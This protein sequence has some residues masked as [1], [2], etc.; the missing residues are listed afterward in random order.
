MNKGLQKKT[1]AKSGARFY[2][3]G[4]LG[5]GSEVRL[6]AEA[7]HHAARVLRLNPGDPV[8]LFDGHGGEFEARILRMDRSEVTVKTG[9]HLTVERE[10]PLEILLA[11][12]LSSGDRMDLTL[13]KSVELGVAAIQPVA[14]E[15]SVVKLKDERAAR[16]AEH[17]QNLVIA[18]CEQCGRNRVPPV[19]Q[20]LGL[21]EWLAQ[22][23]KPADDVRL[24]LSP[25]A[26]VS[27]R[28]LAPPRRRV[29]LL[30]GPEGG[31]APGEV[32]AA[33]SRGFVSVRLGPRVLRTETAALAA[34]A[35]IQAMW[36]DF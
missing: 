19:A 29:I 1:A 18:A 17:W 15:R 10:A 33:E 31:F 21:G 35:A 32:R 3:P 2:F 8:T 16:R 28:D 23:N 5:N 26:A 34:L 11:Q 20:L 9:A 14:T 36:G 25:L 6:P 24:M 30:A 27:L 7:V 13:Q 4:K 22:L 12:G